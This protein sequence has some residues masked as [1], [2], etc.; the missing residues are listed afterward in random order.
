MRV[1]DTRL[2]VGL[3]NEDV[4]LVNESDPESSR[5][6]LLLNAQNSGIPTAK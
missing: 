3:H 1:M 6:A 4:P 5:C 2:G